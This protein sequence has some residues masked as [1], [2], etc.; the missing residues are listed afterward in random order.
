[1]R[2]ADGEGAA[3]FSALYQIMIDESVP[4][5]KE[6]EDS[7]EEDNLEEGMIN[8]MFIMVDEECMRSALV[9]DGTPFVWAVDT[10]LCSGE[11]L[12]YPGQFKVAVTSLVPKLYA[13]LL[14]YEPAEV[15]AARAEGGGGRWGL[16]RYGCF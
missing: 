15:W 10:N 11:T 12:A 9:K 4:G 7:G 13:A 3:S 8:P 2:N 1:M 14:V 5:G 6:E 16:E